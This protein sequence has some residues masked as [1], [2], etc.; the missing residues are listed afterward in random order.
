MVRASAVFVAAILVLCCVGAPA[1]A[2][3]V[4][5]TAGC[6]PQAQGMD[7]FN[8]CAMLEGRCY[9]SAKMCHQAYETERII[10][11][12]RG[13]VGAVI[14]I[15]APVDLSLDDALF[16]VRSLYQLTTSTLTYR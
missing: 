10:R 5:S 2:C 13:N 4:C 8:M 6:I 11:H 12:P 16:I 14:K 7:G 1:F 3:E 9:T 15:T